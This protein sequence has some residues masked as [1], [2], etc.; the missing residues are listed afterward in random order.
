[1][2]IQNFNSNEDIVSAYEGTSEK[3]LKGA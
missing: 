3:D 2:Y 1:M